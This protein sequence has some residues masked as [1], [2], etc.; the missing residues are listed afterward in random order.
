[1]KKQDKEDLKKMLKKREMEDL[2]KTKPEKK[3][4]ET[5][6]E[7]MQSK[8]DE[9]PPFPE[10]KKNEEDFGRGQDEKVS[11]R[12]EDDELEGDFD[13]VDLD[14][15]SRDIAG[16]PFEIWA[17][18]KPGVK[19]LTEKEKKLIGKPLARVLSKYD[20]AKY[21]KDEFLL[22]A[23][24]GFSIMSRLKDSQ[25]KEDDKRI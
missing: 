22:M 3:E 1:M 9:L 14:E 10:P 13:A 24:V 8:K 18:L 5:G 17:V 12:V 11:D 16:V 15:L 25:K 23:V 21:A 20:V 4:E 6:Q 2:K 7:K 19:P